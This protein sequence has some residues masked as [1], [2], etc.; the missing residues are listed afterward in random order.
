MTSIKTPH[1][2]RRQRLVQ[3]GATGVVSAILAA[4]ASTPEPNA[5]VEQARAEFESLQTVPGVQQRAGVAYREA[6]DAYGRARSAWQADKDEDRVNHLASIAERRSQIAQ[7]VAARQLAQA[8]IDASAKERDALVAKTRQFEKQQAEA[9]SQLL[10]RENESLRAENA[11]AQERL[12]RLNA[13]LA[14]LSA[15]QTERGSVVTLDG[16]LFETGSAVLKSGADRKLSKVAEV[17]QN[18]PQSKV[19]IEGFTDATGG[20]SFNRE[21][22]QRRADSVRIDLLRKG[23]AAERVKARGLGES[24]PVASNDTQAGRQ[25]NRRVELIISDGSGNI[26]ERASLRN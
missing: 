14:D 4:C 8:Q 9:R 20:E 11:Q 7:S 6:E 17:L 10:Q 2:N 21:L 13:E 25:Q 26:E 5:Q 19:L 3:V 23:V 24:Y 22:S 1:R 12:A 18:N 15:K 16:V